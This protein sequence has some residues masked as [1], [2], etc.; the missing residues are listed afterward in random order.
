MVTPFITDNGENLELTNQQTGE[1]MRLPRYGYWEDLGRQ[2]PEVKE[3]S[4][5]LEYLKKKYNVPDDHVVDMSKYRK[6]IK[7]AAWG[8]EIHANIIIDR[9]TVGGYRNVAAINM[10]Q[11]F[12]GGI[13][14]FKKHLPKIYQDVVQFVNP[15][16]GETVK[17]PKYDT[18][19]QSV[20]GREVRDVLP[21]GIKQ[22]PPYEPTQYEPRDRFQE[23]KDMNEL[24][25]FK[26]LIS[27]CM[28]EIK[29]E[30]NP[31][32]RLKEA[33]RNVVR[34]ALNEM[35]VSNEP[36]D[37]ADADEKKKIEK[38]FAEKGNERLNKTNQKL[39]EELQSIVEGID[40]TYK[41]YWDDHDDLVVIAHNL[42]AVRITPKFENNFDIEAYTKLHDRIRA[43]AQTWDQVK[44]FVKTNVGAQKATTKADDAKKKAMD[45]YDD[46]D[47]IKKA[48]GPMGDAIKNRGEKKNGEDA[49]LGTTKKD[50]KDYKEDQV[51]NKEDLPDK[52]M[53]Q[54]TDPG[55]D[56]KSLNKNIEKTSKVKPPKN[57]KSPTNLRP[58]DKATPKFRK[59]Q[60]RP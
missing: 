12:E 36:A 22:Q 25:K 60:V 55:K 40:K 47:V 5:D 17:G 2:K 20:K 21:S 1:V 51:Q 18:T 27:E 13:E 57:E 32:L 49:K 11:G 15:E 48:A 35:A 38:G 58:S 56:P 4:D 34:E 10:L 44:S 30:R 26:S 28:K 9:E 14:K 52:P 46:R 43:L 31:R 39:L 19:E 23:N 33:L 53:K 29:L 45:H 54:V 8:E 41:V 42:L 6:N 7:E 50:D 37:Q 16:N 3:L 59:K 24:N